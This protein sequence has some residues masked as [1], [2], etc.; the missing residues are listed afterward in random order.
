MGC[1]EQKLKS[2]VAAVD[3]E[4]GDAFYGYTGPGYTEEFWIIDIDGTRLMITA[5]RSP[6]SPTDDL[7]E[8]LAILNSI[9]IEP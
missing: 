2:W 5:G 9:R 8:L 3:T 1:D 4:P 6:D 7:E